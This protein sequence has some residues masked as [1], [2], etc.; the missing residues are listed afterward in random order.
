MRYSMGTLTYYA[1]DMKGHIRW[2]TWQ[3]ISNNTFQKRGNVLTM[4]SSNAISVG[5]KSLNN[6]DGSSANMSDFY[7][8]DAQFEFWPDINHLD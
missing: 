7:L 6:E 1:S 2:N 4:L 3:L 5:N 8:G